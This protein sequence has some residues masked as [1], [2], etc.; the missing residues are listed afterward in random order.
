[1][2]SFVELTD[3]EYDEIMVDDGPDND[4][5]V[6]EPKVGDDVEEPNVGMMFSSEEEVRSYYMKYAMH[7]WFRVCGRNSRQ[8]DDGKVRWFT[9]VCLRQ[10]TLRLPMSSS[11]DKQ[12]G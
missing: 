2:A 1:M 10:G 6:E 4:D 11:Q 3:N 12:R 5:G 7:K 8:S 9:L